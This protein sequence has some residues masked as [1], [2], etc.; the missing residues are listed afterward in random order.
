MRGS[1]NSTYTHN[2]HTQYL[3]PSGPSY[4]L[5]LRLDVFLTACLP[6]NTLARRVHEFISY[7][8]RTETEDYNHHATYSR[9]TTRYEGSASHAETERRWSSIAYRVHRARIEQ[10]YRCYGLLTTY[11][12]QVRSSVLWPPWPRSCSFLIR[13]A[14]DWRRRSY[15]S[16]IDSNPTQDAISAVRGQVPRNI[17]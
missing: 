4:Q 15:C 17:A 5:L 8:R 10:S 12:E 6:F 2:V 14:V 11:K 16:M 1:A 9:G 13:K 3:I 7:T